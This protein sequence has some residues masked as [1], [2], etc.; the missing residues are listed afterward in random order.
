MASHLA[1]H[2]KVSGKIVH[3]RARARR[4]NHHRAQK[5][6]STT[7]RESHANRGKRRRTLDFF[8]RR[9]R[10]SDVIRVALRSLLRAKAL[11][12]RRERSDYNHG[13]RSNQ[14]AFFA[15]R[16]FRNFKIAASTSSLVSAFSI[17]RFKPSI[18][19]PLR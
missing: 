14:P 7:K 18:G 16:V 2:K 19:S 5:H 12:R 8:C 4:T 13:S 3:A 11:R 6:E 10:H 17:V 15:N 1:E 9:R